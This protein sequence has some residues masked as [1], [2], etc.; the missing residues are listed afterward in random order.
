LI[1]YIGDAIIFY[2]NDEISPEIAELLAQSARRPS[3]LPSIDSFNDFPS[4]EEDSLST[5]APSADVDL[6]VKTFAPIVDFFS[7][8]PNSVFNDPAYY[9]TALSGENDSAQKLHNIL[10]KYLTC[11]D[12]KDRTVYRQQLVTIYWELVKSVAPKMASPSVVAPKKMLLRFGVVLPTLFTPEYKDVFSSVFLHNESGEPVYYIDEWFRDIACGRVSLSATDE[13]RP[14]RKNGGGGNDEASRLMQLQSK[15]NGKLQN[16]ENMISAKESERLL[17]ES[18]LRAKIDQLCDHAPIPSLPNHKCCLTDIQRRSLNEINDRLKSL[19]KVDKELSLYISEYN[20]A[21]GIADSLQLKLE[22]APAE[23]EV[24]TSDL[25]VEVD[26]VRQMAKMTVGRQGNHFPLFTKEFFHCTP[27]QTGFRENVID[28]LAWVESLDPGAF[29]RVHKNHQNRI[30]P[31][32]VLVPTYG[33]TGFCWEPFDRYNRVTSRGRI[34]VPMY[35]RNLQIA[36]LMA[37]ADLRWQVAKEKA[38]YYWMEEGLTGQYYQWFSSQKLK[39]DL[40]DY[41]INDYILWMTK[42][43][44]GVQRLEKDVRGI[45]W[46]HIPFAQEVKDKLKTRSLVYQELYQRD[47]NRSMSD[48]Y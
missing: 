25:L 26:T 37:V 9:K 27:R 6:S 40:K 2:M 32:V 14:T 19:L 22:N 11:Q 36:I 15:N 39:G 30:I 13:A 12:P 33:D 8:T 29:C 21:K 17:I 38:S 34:V 31:Y 4:P 45:F 47:I 16:A 20:D 24:N 5:S 48:G 43:S 3:S 10:S 46:R 23:A 42:E 41:F 18:D 1:F 28:M 44:E 35:P 7:K